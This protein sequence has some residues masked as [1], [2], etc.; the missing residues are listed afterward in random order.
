MAYFNYHAK[1]KQLIKENKLMFYYFT[2]KHN[3]ISPALVLV[4]NDDKHHLMPI[5]KEHWQEY[6]NILPKSK[7]K[8]F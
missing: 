7:L 5:R 8:Y 2:E 3:K 1:A 6:L 4:F